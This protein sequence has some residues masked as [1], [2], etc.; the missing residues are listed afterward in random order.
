VNDFGTPNSFFESATCILAPLLLFR[1]NYSKR[2]YESDLYSERRKKPDSDNLRIYIWMDEFKGIKQMKIVPAILAENYDDFLGRLRLAESFADYVQ[3]DIMDGSFVP[4]LSFPAQ[5]L[6]KV[7]TSLSFEVHL[8]VKHP[9]AFMSRIFNPN[10]K[11]VIFHFESDVKPFDFIE[12]MKKR[13]LD[14]GMAIK[15]ETTID[16]FEKTAEMLDTLLFLT[17]DPCCYGNPFKPE[18]VEKIRKARLMFKNKTMAADGGA[19]LDNLKLFVEAGL[20]YVC[21]GSRI[22][23]KGDPARNYKLFQEKLAEFE[24]YK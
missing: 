14:V 9:F 8:M 23:L 5:E 20:D 2:S 22:F 12:Q 11:K 16:L 13:G 1:F 17:V 6:N 3:I 15:P 19:S 7:K 18:V 21:V 4:T 24:V 10:L